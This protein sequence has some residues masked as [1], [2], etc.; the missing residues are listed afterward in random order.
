MT[1]ESVVHIV[2]DDESVRNSLAFL[3]TTSGIAAR[4]HISATAFLALAPS[5]DGACLIT[6][7]RMPD[8]NGIDLLHRLRDLHLSIPVIIVTGHGDV[9]LAVDAMKQGAI[10][11]IE[12]PFAEQAILEAIERARNLAQNQANHKLE[13][14]RARERF[15]M[16]SE[17]E[18]QVLERVVAGAPNKIIAHDLGLSP[19]TVE[20][21]RAN[22]M[23]K[24]HAK[25]LAELVR[26]SIALAEGSSGQGD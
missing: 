6:D 22:L 8:M 7:V 17:R 23:A 16:L 13:R 21:Y 11:F 3:L 25:G 4:T 2:D 10:D 12:K 1:S 20:V 9:Q 18:R 5:L 26:I 14:E 19:R 24:L 15:E